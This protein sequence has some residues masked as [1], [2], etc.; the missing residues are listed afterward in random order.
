[1]MDYTVQNF[2]V[3]KNGWW[4]ILCDNRQLLIVLPWYVHKF[5][6][7]NFRLIRKKNIYRRPHGT[8]KT[9]ANEAGLPCYTLYVAF[10]T[11]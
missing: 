9:I 8:D 11:L 10:W 6:G 7:D 3:Q 5:G 4:Q 2:G 1:M